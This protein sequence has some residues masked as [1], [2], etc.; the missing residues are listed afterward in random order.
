MGAIHFVGGEKGG[1]GKSLTARLLAQYSIDQKQQLIAFDSDQS[2]G[3]FSRFY[4][5]FTQPV[6]INNFDS[7]DQ[8]IAA[9]EK[10]PDATIIV[11][12]AAQTGRHL[13]DWILQTD[14]FSIL[15]CLD[16][17]PYFWHVMDDGADST[18][19]LNKML[20]NITHTNVNIVVVKN[21]G[22][23][24]CFENFEHSMI[25]TKAEKMGARIIEL[26]ALQARLAQKVDFNNTSFWAAAHNSEIMTLTERHRVTQWIKQCY[27]EFEIALG[28]KDSNK[29]LPSDIHP[30]P[31][32]QHYMIDA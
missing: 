24:Q 32:E 8:I 20:D 15:E 11:D 22:R 6:A 30:A 13:S 10:N 5:D 9:A 26:P 29:E 4:K 31:F 23:G 19:L 12:L 18:H 16:F 3:T 1:V 21:F 28:Q 7:L 27:S 25:H 14:I 2:H 17:K